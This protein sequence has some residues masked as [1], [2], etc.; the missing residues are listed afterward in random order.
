MRWLKRMDWFDRL[1][2]RSF[3]ALEQPPQGLS[4][5]DLDNAAYLDDTG[6]GDLHGG[7]YAFRQLTIRL[8]P[9]MPLAPL[10]WFPGIRFIGVAVYGWI[11]RH[12]YHISACRLSDRRPD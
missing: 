2:F 12:R 11:A 5:R 7:F 6:H 9:L 3:Q 10:F 8:L 1:T 4:W